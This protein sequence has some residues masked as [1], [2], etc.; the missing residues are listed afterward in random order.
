MDKKN[1]IEDKLNED[2]RVDTLII[3]AGMTGMTTAYYLKDFKNI[4]I[5][6]AG[7]IGRGVTLGSTAK[8]NYLQSGIYSKIKRARGERL[9]RLY[10]KSQKYAIDHLKEIIESEQIDCNFERVDSYLFSHTEEEK[11]TVSKE[12]EFLLNQ[13]VNLKKEELPLEIES[14]SSYKVD[15]TYI[16]NPIKYLNRITKI[17]TSSGVPIYENTKIIKVEKSTEGYTSYTESG[18]KIYSKRVVIATHYPY[19]T[20]NLFLQLK[21]YCEKSYIVVSKTNKDGNFTCINTRN[22]IYSCRFYSDGI[23]SYQ[24]LLSESHNI[25]FKQNDKLHF[26]TLIERF[27]LKEKDTVMMYS[28]TDI[29]TPD[30]MP[31]IGKLTENMYIASGFNTW[32]MTN[33]VLSASIISDDILNRNNRFSKI[34]NPKRI[35]IASI[36]YLPY[37]L[38]SQIKSYLGP[39]IHK[40][41]PW[42]NENVKFTREGL[43]TY[44]IYTDRKGATHKVLNRCPHM[45]CSLI[46]N[47]V[48]HTWDC[49]CHSSRFDI[50]GNC[51]KGPSNYDI[52]PK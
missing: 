17:L 36:L 35:T 34:F 31:L 46:F 15:D 39:K 23:N 48:E 25:A 38:F 6:D 51:I 49:P 18:Y 27:N 11:S 30:G 16:F 1:T 21:S 13:G 33:S 4:C 2:K 32:G 14:Y 19:F 7:M 5:V 42:Y 40:K 10:L 9:A 50:D 44:G 28:N 45:G 26:K 47:E 41:K 43:K 37:I 52:K 29:I 8:I 12:V 22:P 24:I 20:K 3:G